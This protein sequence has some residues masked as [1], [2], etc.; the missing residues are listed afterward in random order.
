MA[1]SGEI[2]FN[3]EFRGCVEPDIIDKN[4]K[5]GDPQKKMTKKASKMSIR[6]YANAM[7]HFYKKNFDKAVPLFTEAIQL[8]PWSAQLFTKRG[9]AYL[10]KTCPNACIKDCNRAL[11]LD[12]NS[13]AAFKYRG[14]AYSL[15]GK[16]K[17]AEKDLL[18]ASNINS[19]EETEEWL[20]AV[21]FYAKENKEYEKGHENRKA[22]KEVRKN[23]GNTREAGK[24]EEIEELIDEWLNED[25]PYTKIIERYRLRHQIGQSEKEGRA[26]LER[27]NN[28][29]EVQAKDSDSDTGHNTGKSFNVFRDP[30]VLAAL[31]DS[32]ISDAFATIMAN[33][34]HIYKY[35]SNSKLMAQLNILN[36]KFAQTGSF[37]GL[38]NEEFLGSGNMLGRKVP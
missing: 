24:G 14:K 2:Y 20:K 21:L 9:Q 15:L 35:E 12:P 3:R 28:T 10:N 25:T 19:D 29:D 37:P 1:N 26:R 18:Q 13:A 33:P 22:I 6:K 36:Q 30:E 27:K 5:M 11:E 7:K 8:N 17:E 32:Q 16:W 23:S 31:A 4:Q 38:T 34:D